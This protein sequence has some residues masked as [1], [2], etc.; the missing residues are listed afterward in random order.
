V[1][2]RLKRDE[3][4]VTMGLTVIMIV[5]I[6]VMG[7]GLLVFVSRDLE[8]VIEVNRGQLAQEAADAGLEAARRH[9][10]TADALPSRYDATNTTG[11]SDWYDD[12]ENDA[13]DDAGPKVMTF[14][15]SNDVRVGIRYLTPSATETQAR[16]PN[17]APEV[18]PTYAGDVCNDT[19]GDGV[20]DDLNTT[21]IPPNVDACDYPNNRN[22]FRVTVRGISG[23]TLRQ[24][25]AIYS[26]ENFDLPVAFYATR[27]VDFNG[28]ATNVSGISIFANRY[29]YDLRPSRITGNDSRYGNW[30]TDPVS[31]QPNAFN[32]VPRTDSLGNPVLAAGA[33]ALGTGTEGTPACP[34]TQ[35][36]GIV[37]D[38]TSTNTT[39]K[40]GTAGTSQRYGIRDYDRH[41]D[42]KCSGTTP[43]TSGRPDFRAN[44]WGALESQPS[45]IMT[46]PFAAGTPA[47][48]T[49]DN[50]LLAELKQ[51]AQ[52]K[53]LY[54][55][56]DPGQSFTIDDNGGDIPRYP[57]SSD[58]TDTVMFIEFANPD[59]SFTE[60][61]GNAVAKGSVLF[62]ASSSDP[63]NLVKGTI[64]VVN[65][66]FETS[67]SGKDDFQGVIIVRD[68]VDTDNTSDSR[69]M[70]FNMGGSFNIEGYANIEGDMFLGGSI[71]GF[72]P[73]TLV[74]GVPG[75][76]KVSLWS[77]RECYTMTC[78]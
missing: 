16:Q 47:A 75:L 40:A 35:T 61:N 53:D 28:N 19:N 39:Q 37:Y 64:V 25:Q 55:R 20:D 63:D 6:G 36:S 27:D 41:S 3:S 68:P 17:F 56:L 7:A 34:L 42:F 1:I 78:N 69:V 77:W 76:F 62:K 29:I 49:A 21:I 66:D 60:A 71:D 33:A 45:S 73:A 11:N 8:H 65:G 4:G 9:L 31:G 22:Y 44:T 72:L 5:L 48:V 13:A 14:E 38:P 52:D 57:G 70:T 10:A 26:T 24:I 18:L 32:G 46:F 23:N 43:V 58:L 50:E 2:R 67:P 59:G 51:K 54:R 15:D 12:P 74:N 30:A